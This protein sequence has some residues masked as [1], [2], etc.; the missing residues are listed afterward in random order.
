MGAEVEIAFAGET[1]RAYRARPA[2]GRGRGVLVLP[3]ASGLTASL[4]GAC[5]RLAR[6]GFATLAPDLAGLDPGPAERLLAAAVR[7]LVSDEGTDGSRIGALGLGAGGA[8]ALRTAMASRRIGAVVDVGGTTDFELGG[9]TVPVLCIFPE[10][11]VVA[12]EALC[13]R[14]AASARTDLVTEPGV[15]EG[16]FDESRADRFDAPAATRTW[17]RLLAFFRA[18]LA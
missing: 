5:D 15:A 1:A 6:E 4:R 18:E 2:A 17:E 8:W 3:D 16:F 11:Q 14:L 10:D 13:K 7:E 9:L 12:A